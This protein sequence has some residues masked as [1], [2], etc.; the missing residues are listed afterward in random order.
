MEILLPSWPSSND[1]PAQCQRAV[2]QQ[3]KSYSYTSVLESSAI[4]PGILTMS[5]R[6]LVVAQP[7]CMQS[8]TPKLKAGSHKNN[9]ETLSQN[10]WTVETSSSARHYGRLYE[11]SRS[12]DAIYQSGI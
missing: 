5:A 4:L 8:R 1:H 7:S 10:K 2:R 11:T 3:I 9:N 6:V 12:G